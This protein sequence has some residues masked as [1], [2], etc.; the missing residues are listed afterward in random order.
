MQENIE[1]QQEAI[2]LEELNAKE[3]GEPKSDLL[4]RLYT[5]KAQMLFAL[6]N[7][8][9]Q[10]SIDACEQALEV[11]RSRTEDYTEEI[12]K[13]EMFIKQHKS[14]LEEEMFYRHQT[15]EDYRMTS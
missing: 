3:S 15:T 1:F 5:V 2:E 14:T 13:L 6:D 9:Q 12:Q 10:E 11:Y 4:G 7:G 8:R